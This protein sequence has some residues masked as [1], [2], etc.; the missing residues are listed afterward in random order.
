MPNYTIESNIETV[1]K[2]Q[3]EVT[4]TSSDPIFVMEGDT[5]VR[6]ANL[7]DMKDIADTVSEN[8]HRSNTLVLSARGITTAQL[9]VDTIES[10]VGELN[11]LDFDAEYVVAGEILISF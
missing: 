11:L 3:F 7:L 4:I 5:F 10:Q 6:V 9:L 8:L 2:D 1:A